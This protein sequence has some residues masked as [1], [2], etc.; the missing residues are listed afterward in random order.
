LTWGTKQRHKCKNK[1]DLFTAVTMDNASLV[2]PEDLTDDAVVEVIPRLL[3]VTFREVSIFF[4]GLCE[5]HLVHG[6]P[7]GD[8]WEHAFTLRNDNIHDH[9]SW[10][11]KSLLEGR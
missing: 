9:R 1:R 7:S 5:E 3:A 11:S 4:H 8:H 6:T 10:R 2:T